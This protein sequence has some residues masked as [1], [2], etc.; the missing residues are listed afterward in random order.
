MTEQRSIPDAQKALAEATELAIQQGGTVHEDALMDAAEMAL[1]G[2]S[3]E[4]MAERI[5]KERAEPYQPKG[6]WSLGR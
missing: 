5:K 2:Q 1:D 3:I 6:G 4:S